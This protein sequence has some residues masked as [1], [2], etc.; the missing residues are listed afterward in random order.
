MIRRAR[1][2]LNGCRR[3]SRGF[4][5]VEMVVALGILTLTFTMA[6]GSIFQALSIQRFWQE[7]AVATMESRHAGSWFSGDALFAETTSLVDGAVPVNNVTLNWTDGLG[8]SHTAVYAVSGSNLTRTIDGVQT[9]LSD[10]VVSVGFSLSGQ[11]LTL[12]IEVQADRGGTESS[13]LAA[14]LRMLQS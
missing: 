5:L 6:G 1:Q 3:D 12:D 2:L 9:I 13:S 10:R 11:T 4:T 8:V 14:Y 7:D